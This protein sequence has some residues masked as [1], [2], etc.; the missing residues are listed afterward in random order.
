MNDAGRAS[1]VTS[2]NESNIWLVEKWLFYARAHR[3]P[4]VCNRT[5]WE[6]FEL[7][8][9]SL[10]R[11]LSARRSGASFTD[12]VLPGGLDRVCRGWRALPT[13]TGIW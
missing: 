7:E 12:W 8:R 11:K 13:A 9:L 10:T 3:N 1:R 6:H 4:A 5:I 2:F